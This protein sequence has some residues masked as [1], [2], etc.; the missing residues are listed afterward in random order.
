MQETLIL[1]L[2]IRADQNIGVFSMTFLV[3]GFHSCLSPLPWFFT[4]SSHLPTS[5]IPMFNMP[6]KKQIDDHDSHASDLLNCTQPT[7]E[8]PQ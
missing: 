2:L 1:V 8:H 6:V 4:E 5:S 3:I 7:V